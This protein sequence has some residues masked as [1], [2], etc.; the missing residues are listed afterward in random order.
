MSAKYVQVM[1]PPFVPAFMLEELL[2]CDTC[3]SRVRQVQDL[4][5]LEDELFG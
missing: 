5:S 4:P 3:R 1:M 2:R